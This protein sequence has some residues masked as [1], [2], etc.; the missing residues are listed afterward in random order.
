MRTRQQLA[1]SRGLLSKK[2]KE[3]EVSVWL[4]RTQSFKGK[5]G[6]E[7]EKERNHFFRTRQKEDD[8][9]RCSITQTGK[10]EPKTKRLGEEERNQEEEGKTSIKKKVLA[11]G[12]RKVKSGVLP[13]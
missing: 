7:R 3:D 4:E 11:R 8:Q 10:S 13:T 9:L 5:C 1:G 2:K 12:E 6:M